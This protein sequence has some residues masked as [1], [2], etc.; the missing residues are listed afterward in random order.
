VLNINLF[1]CILFVCMGIH[2]RAHV[3]V[4]VCVGG[5]GPSLPSI[6]FHIVSAFLP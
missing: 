2:A 1:I 6:S 5:G 3:C 4:C